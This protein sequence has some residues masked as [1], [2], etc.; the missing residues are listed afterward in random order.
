M[1]TTQNGQCG[2]F[3]SVKSV[4]LCLCLEVFK[5]SYALEARAQVPT[6][7]YV[8]SSKQNLALGTTSCTCC[9]C[10]PPAQACMLA[11]TPS[12]C[13]AEPTP[14]SP[15]IYDRYWACSRFRLYLLSPLLRHLSSRCVDLVSAKC[16]LIMRVFST[17]LFEHQSH[18]PIPE[19]SKSP[20]FS[21][22]HVYTPW[23]IKKLH[24]FYP[25]SWIGCRLHEITHL[26]SS[27]HWYTLGA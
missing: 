4:T 11:L 22:Y 10:C 5:G 1:P 16:H 19:L 21:L 23:H 6:A 8:P 9:E 17:M 13:H 12:L 14:A 27:V 7:T 24:I 25:S 26:R 18:C 20:I 3:P 15:A 2:P